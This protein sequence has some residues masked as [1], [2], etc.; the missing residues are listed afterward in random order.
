V[1]ATTAVEENEF[2][3]QLTLQMDVRRK[4]E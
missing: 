1:L 2:V 3:H 4:S